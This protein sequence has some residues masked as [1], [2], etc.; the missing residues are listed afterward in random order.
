MA[1][2]NKAQLRGLPR[3]QG[4]NCAQMDGFSLHANTF[5]GPAARD[6]LYKLVKYLCRPSIAG[7]RVTEQED[8]RFRVEL[9]TA[10][11]DGT[12][13]VLLS[14]ANLTA[15][16]A[17]LIPLPG[18]PTIRYYGA[19]APN[20][21][22]WPL[23]VQA[24]ELAPRRRDKPQPRAHDCQVPLSDAEL[25]HHAVEQG[26]RDSGRLGCAQAMKLAWKA[27]V[28][29]CNCG[30]R[31]KLVALIDQPPVVKKILAHLGLATEALTK[32]ED[33]IWR[34]RGP[35][36]ELFPLDLDEAGLPV[37]LSAIEEDP[38]EPFFDELPVDDW[39]A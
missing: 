25:A 34:V 12:S 33:P 23:V 24:G 8:C 11:R 6:E 7:K 5:V 14:P 19:F 3:P 9:K 36:D 15:R 35:P 27:D 4:R 1:L 22:L 32:P 30:G 38:G 13:A 37:E 28:L 18:R 16:M 21:K 31:R 10:W 17:A 29:Q 2:K 39:A 26:R 20:A